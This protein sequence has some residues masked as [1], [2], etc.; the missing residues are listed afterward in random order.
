MRKSIWVAILS[1]ILVVGITVSSA[2]AAVELIYTYWG[3]PLERD[4]QAK[5]CRDFEKAYQSI[6]P[7]IKVKDIYIPSNYDEK[8]NAMIAAGEP[9]H[10]AQLGEALSLEWAEKGILMDILPL[11]KQDKDPSVQ[12]ENRLSMTWYWYDKGKKTIGTNLAAE[13][14]VL[15]YNKEI[16]D[17]A[18]IPYPASNPEAWT[19]EKFLDTAIKLTTDRN[20]RHPGDPG[21]DPSNIDTYGVAFGTWWGP[22]L[23]FIWS[24]GG[25]ICDPEGRRPLINSPASVEAIQ[26]LADLMLK[27][28]VAPTPTQMQAFPALRIALQTKKVAM[29]ID[30]QWALLDLGQMAKEGRLKLGVAPL[31]KLRK[32]VCLELGAPN[33]MFVASAQKALKESWE[34]YKWTTNSEKVISL[35]RGGLWMPLQKWYYTNPKYT[36]QWLDPEVHP[37]E[38]KPAVIDYLLKYG[39]RSPSYY[40]RNWGKISDI[41]YQELS[42]VWLGK[43]SAKTACDNIA[44]K[45]KP[46]LV[47]RY[48]K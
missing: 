25:D 33:V 1:L 3:S 37:P 43:V 20:G 40:L 46:L 36:A 30:G 39:R 4:A 9:P 28:H 24:N 44:N 22:I 5:M 19:W 38:Y 15:W 7:G 42:N 11:I 26:K 14:M 21:F 6:F 47:G 23:P 34:F 32:P 16:F 8:I 13:V 10:V 41:M 27:Y 12:I 35:I 2:T 29:Y 45:I 31:P 18:G 48:D 17:K